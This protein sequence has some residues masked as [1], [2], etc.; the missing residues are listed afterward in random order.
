M[1]KNKLWN[2]LKARSKIDP[3]LQY[4]ED[5]FPLVQQRSHFLDYICDNLRSMQ[6]GN[7]LTAEYMLRHECQCGHVV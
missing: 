3:F 5:Y 4:K 7:N 2:T 6:N 1:S